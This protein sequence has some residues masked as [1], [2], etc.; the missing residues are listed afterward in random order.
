MVDTCLVTSARTSTKTGLRSMQLASRITTA[1][2][3]VSSSSA[4]ATTSRGVRDMLLLVLLVPEAAAV[5]AVV[6]VVC[7]L[8]FAF[9][10][11]SD[12]ALSATKSGSTKDGEKRRSWAAPSTRSTNPATSWPVTYVVPVQ[13]ASERHSVADFWHAAITSSRHDST[14]AHACLCTA[15]VSLLP[16]SS[17]PRSPSRS[18]SGEDCCCC[19]PSLPFPSPTV[20]LCG[21]WRS[22]CRASTVGYVRNTAIS[23][24]EQ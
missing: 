3:H 24:A 10:P 15:S 11:V 1:A 16:R 22:L 9:S 7:V 5:A 13:R 21:G 6:P 4:D 8:A 14:A 19:C 17:S 23:R 18:G 12:P 2:A 20:S